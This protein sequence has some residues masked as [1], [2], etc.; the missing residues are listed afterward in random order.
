[1]AAAEE[2]GWV[3]KSNGQCA[4]KIQLCPSFFVFDVWRLAFGDFITFSR[5]AI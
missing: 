3:P 1:V 4:A 2:E 5:G